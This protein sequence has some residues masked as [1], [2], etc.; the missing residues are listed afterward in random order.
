MTT[1]WAAMAAMLRLDDAR[2][3]DDVERT[4]NDNRRPDDS[5]NSFSDLLQ[6]DRQRSSAG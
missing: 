1:I 6:R 2:S 5:D 3:G 4:P